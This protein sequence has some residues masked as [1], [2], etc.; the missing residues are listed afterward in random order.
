MPTLREKALEEAGF[1]YNEITT[2]SKELGDY[3]CSIT[4]EEGVARWNIDSEEEVGVCSGEHIYDQY[5]IHLADSAL[6]M[7]ANAPKIPF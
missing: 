2:Y 5:A 7:L 1:Y 4:F 6:K 3:I